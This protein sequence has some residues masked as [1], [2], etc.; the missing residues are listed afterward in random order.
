MS[1][2]TLQTGHSEIIGRENQVEQN[3]F[4]M[5]YE[6]L[7]WKAIAIEWVNQPG[8]QLSLHLQFSDAS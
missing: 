1:Q 5:S 7:S 8:K 2:L 4:N 3:S 6:L